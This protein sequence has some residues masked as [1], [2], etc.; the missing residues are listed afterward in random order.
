MM[1]TS[2][3]SLAAGVFFTVAA[4]SSVGRAPILASHQTNT[5]TNLT[6]FANVVQSLELNWVP[7]YAP[8]FQCTYLTVPLDYKNESAGTTDIAYLR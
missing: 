2:F 1:A 4:A 8:M 5:T 6:T 7:C 3:Q